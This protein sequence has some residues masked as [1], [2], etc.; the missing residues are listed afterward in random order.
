MRFGWTFIVGLIP[1][2]GDVSD[3]VLNYTLVIKKAKKADIP[4]WLLHRMLLNNVISA[5][6]GFI[7]LV[8]DIILASYKANSRNAALLEEFLRIRGEELL[9]GSTQNAGMIQPGAGRKKDE[10]VPGASTSSSHRR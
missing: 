8:G 9:K 4:D 1:V 3:A 10:V 6:V 5:G 2:V 7:P